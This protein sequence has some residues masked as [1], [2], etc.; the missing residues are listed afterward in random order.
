M[1]R[2]LK[3][4]VVLIS[5]FCL[6][7]V[8][9][10]QQKIERESRIPKHDVPREARDW[11][12]DSFEQIRRVKWYEEISDGGVSYEAKFLLN[13]KFHSVEFDENGKIQD[14]EIELNWNDLDPV[15]GRQIEKSIGEKLDL[16]KI[17]RVQIQ[18]SGQEDDLEDFFDED[19]QE[20][21][22]TRYEIE[23]LAKKHDEGIKLFEGLFE[24]NGRLVLVREVIVRGMDNL[25]F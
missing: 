20:G 19:E 22:V 23:F 8:G 15:L 4:L 14:V 5:S 10:S 9:Y 12:A 11:L 13:Q 3:F 7:S 1:N 21:I 6:V 2:M 24:E 18:Y 25:M 17:Q 16:Q